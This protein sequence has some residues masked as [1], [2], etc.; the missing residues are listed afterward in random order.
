[1]LT[2][3]IGIVI[4]ICIGWQFPQPQWAKAAGVW[5]VT[6]AEAGMTYIENKIMQRKS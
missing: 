1:M 4:G 6:K 2:L 3:S 5:I